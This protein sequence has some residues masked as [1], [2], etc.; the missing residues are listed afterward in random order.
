MNTDLL[1]FARQE[2]K[3]SVNGPHNESVV[4]PTLKEIF[5]WKR[6]V[7]VMGPILYFPGEGKSLSGAL[8]FL[9]SG[10]LF[11]HSGLVFH[12]SHDEVSPSS[13]SIYPPGKGNYGIIRQYWWTI[14]FTPLS[15]A[16]IIAFPK[17]SILDEFNI[18]SRFLP[19]C[20]TDRRIEK[21]GDR[22]VRRQND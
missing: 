15:S 4:P 1:A 10:H 16:L 9:W 21:G 13:P 6:K 19:E 12:R 2:V 18:I 22:W 11:T 20:C 17:K 3:I 14:S 5:L 8:K 7:Y